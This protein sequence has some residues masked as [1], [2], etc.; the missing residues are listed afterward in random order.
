MIDK[1]GLEKEIKENKNFEGGENFSAT[2]YFTKH[3][4]GDFIRFVG[5]KNDEVACLNKILR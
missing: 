2:I 1:Y 5:N 4:L 3:Y